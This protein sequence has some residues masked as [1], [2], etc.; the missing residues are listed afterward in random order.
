MSLPRYALLA[1]LFTGHAGA[2][3]LQQLK[4][5]IGG[6][7]RLAARFEQTVQAQ[8][9]KTP[10][11]SSGQ[12]AIQRPGKF[13]WHYQKPFEQLIVGDGEKLWV[14]D[15]D[16]NQVT[17]RRQSSTLGNNPA[18]LLAGSNDIEKHFRFKLLPDRD[19]QEWLEARPQ[20]E[21]SGFQ[22]VRMGFA[23]GELQAMELADNF[24]QT[25]RIRFSQL[26]SA[27]RFDGGVFKF[28]PPKGADVITD[29]GATP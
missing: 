18:A 4:Q 21:D 26:D 9:A 6:S 20:G 14:Y 27:P 5:F 3:A 13:R 25:T 29:P 19:G 8:G 2:D 10:Q 23:K 24:G 16:L 22:W 11:R 12:L 7:Q 15:P 17:S 28:S 1:L